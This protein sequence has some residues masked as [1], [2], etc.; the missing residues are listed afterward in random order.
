M[1]SA[2]NAHSAHTLRINHLRHFHAAQVAAHIPHNLFLKGEEMV[3]VKKVIACTE[4]NAAQVRQVVKQWPALHGLVAGLQAQGVFP[5]LRAL[6]ITLSGN[7]KVVGK[8][9]D[10]LTGENGM[11]TASASTQGAGEV[12]NV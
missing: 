9:L 10:A 11:L 12:R 6:Q 2:H 4:E 3:E 1:H 7:E 8:G 5:G